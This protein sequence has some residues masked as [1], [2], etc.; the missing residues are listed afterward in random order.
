MQEESFHIA[1][2]VPPIPLIVSSHAYRSFV[3]VLK[4]EP[5]RLAM[6]SFEPRQ[7]TRCLTSVFKLV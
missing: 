7:E 6:S 2:D 5:D 4:M 1:D 3:F